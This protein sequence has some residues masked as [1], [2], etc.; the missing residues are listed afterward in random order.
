[1]EVKVL[2]DLALWDT[3]QGTLEDIIMVVLAVTRAMA[4][5]LDM[6]VRSAVTGS[7]GH[8]PMVMSSAMVIR[9]FRMEVCLSSREIFT[10]KRLFGIF[11]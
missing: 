2:T 9:L 6:E 7:R 1:M 8:W 11:V 4:D 10:R 5:R 3:A